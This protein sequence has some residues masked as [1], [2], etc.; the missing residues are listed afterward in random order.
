MIKKG[1]QNMKTKLFL[2]CA[3]FAAIV[4]GST[5]AFAAATQLTVSDVS[6][7]AGGTAT[8]TI[9]ANSGDLAGAAFTVT[10]DSAVFSITAADIT[11][12]FFETFAAM[13]ITPDT[14][15]VESTTYDKA[16]VSN[17]P[18]DSGTVLIAAANAAEKGTAGEDAVLFTL[19]F[20]V[21]ADATEGDYPIGI[22]PTTLN[23]TS[24][25]YS[26][27]GEQIDLLVG[28]DEASTETPYPARLTAGKAADNI[29]AGTVDIVPPNVDGID[30]DDDK[31]FATNDVTLFRRWNA[32][33]TG[34]ALIGGR[35]TIGENA[36]RT[37]AD[38]IIDYLDGVQLTVFDIDGDGQFAS[39][40]V[41]LFR[42]W[43]AGWTGDALIGGRGTIGENAT[44]TTADEIITYLDN[45]KN[46]LSE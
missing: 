16:L 46:K 11:S 38:S 22:T 3:V 17:P 33:W 5:S 32:A 12:D 34:D 23:N 25:G 35:G 43:N 2:A 8:V 30:I 7:S 21:A 42:R 41:T 14:V 20:A 45:L 40:D 27:D 36:T 29:T 31:Q 1:V 24:A 9:T 18:A 19:N 10:F 6:S 44:R 15:T 4:L 26:A 28:I 13:G 37:T 39:N